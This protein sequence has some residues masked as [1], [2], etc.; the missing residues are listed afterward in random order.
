M[1]PR[2]AGLFTRSPLVFALALPLACSDSA[3]E[4]DDVADDTG[5]DADT[6]T[7][8]GTDTGEDALY[9]AQIRRTSHGVAHITA[10]DW[11]SLGFGQGYA[12]TED[13]G[14]LLADQ[15]VKIRSERARWFG[16]GEENA[17]IYS[18]FA[19]KHLR[20]Y[21]IA[22]EQFDVLDDD[23]RQVIEGYAAG[24]NAAIADGKIGGDCD[25]AEWLPTEITAVDLFA[26]YYNLSLLASSWQVAEGIGAAQPP[27]GPN[28]PP[29]PAPHYT[30]V[31][32]HRGVLGS[33]G[34]G[35]GA[36]VSEN[37]RGMVFGNPHFPWEGELQLWESHLVGP[38]GFEVYGVGLLGVPG[39]LIG[40]NEGM[41]W[42]HTF[43]DG[44]RI[45][46]YEISSP[47]GEPTKYYYDDEIRDMESQ[48][49][50]I[51][52]LQPD[53]TLATETRTLWRTH[54][55]PMLALAPFYW[56]EAL[57]LSYRDANI[58]NF[59]IIEQF[60]GMDRA[61][62]LEDFKAVHEEVNGIPWVN[63]ISAS[64]DGRAWY[65]DSTPTP[66]LS[67]EAID[68][69]YDRKDE[70]FTKA[71]ADQD[72]WMFDGSTSRDEWQDD[73]NAARPGIIAPENL[74]QLERGDY[75]FNANDSHW[76]SNPNE[77]LAGYSPLHGFEGTARQPRTRMN[78]VTLEEIANG[79]GF[80]G[81]DGVLDLDEL[82]EAGLA[83][84]G[85]MEE[86]LRQDVV[87]RCTGVGVWEVDNEM[88]DIAEACDVLASWDGLLNLDS[89][90]AIVWREWVADYDYS[91]AWSD[92]D[93]GVL[94]ANPFDVA[95]PVGTPNTLAPAAVNGDRALD[96][97]AR[98]VMR[99]DQAG[100]ALDTP[101]GD[102]QFVRKG[103]TD[104]PVTGGVRN[105]GV[106]NL[107][108]YEHFRSDLE[109]W[110]PRG[111][112]IHDETGLT[113]EGYLVNY[114]SSFIMAMRFTDDGP[115]GR[116]ILTYSQS[117]EPDSGWFSDQT[118]L[119]SNK[120]WRPL[121]WHEADIL[122]DPNLIEY[123]VSGGEATDG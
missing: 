42:T 56:T 48:E 68:A 113:D 115:E 66:N 58:D 34:W 47:P 72:I 12:F 37:G 80:A 102:A 75:V 104:I 35:L 61:T 96:A 28:V 109:E 103:D 64:A 76:M 63:T 20:V 18:D 85:M 26:Y 111:E 122:A 74:P 98:A 16:P 84:R 97:L 114:G 41:A 44:H 91:L 46:L 94:F 29:D 99:L 59:E 95:D 54:Y 9:Q 78:A 17:H 110:I 73:P 119:F 38:E 19:F 60:I 101:L 24:Y 112:V 87:A 30:V 107:M 62:T 71:F 89:V 81:A 106:T 53:G 121:L 108:V 1:T 55:G 70:G 11:G 45:T 27:G 15:I 25:S 51:E 50:S 105:E 10:D 57:A 32:S 21:E 67:Q 2:V 88:V 14:C 8:T 13:K 3:G 22:T 4:T 31:N 79:G 6:G 90:G 49:Y 117:A 118:E 82:T 86:L 100:L 116:G 123:E 33:N 7:D 92:A 36:D 40:F 77:L 23:L 83:N 93:G 39:A 52:V 43:S 120:Q 5:T 65:M 69:W